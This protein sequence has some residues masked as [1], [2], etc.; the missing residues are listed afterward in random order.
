M[1]PCDWN[2]RTSIASRTLSRQTV[3]T[4]PA[5]SEWRYRHAENDRGLEVWLC[6]TALLNRR[7]FCFLGWAAYSCVCTSERRAC[8][9]RERVAAESVSQRP[10]LLARRSH[11]I[12][13]IACRICDD[14]VVEHFCLRNTVCPLEVVSTIN[15][16]AGNRSCLTRPVRQC[17]PTDPVIFQLCYRLQRMTR[18][19]DNQA[20]KPQADQQ[21]IVRVAPTVLQVSSAKPPNVVSRQPCSCSTILATGKT[22]AL[23]LD[24]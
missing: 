4:G 1:I 10:G 17:S 16:R 2:A 9:S 6:S 23:I 18:A 15:A 7:R 8:R 11:S 5:S 21:S 20:D 12:Y 14:L 13:C 3:P 19:D 24:S 22:V